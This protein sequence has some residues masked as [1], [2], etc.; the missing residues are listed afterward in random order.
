MGT[1]TTTTTTTTLDKAGNQYW[2]LWFTFWFQ[3]VLEPVN[4][5]P[6][7]AG[8]P[9]GWP[10]TWSLCRQGRRRKRAQTGWRKEMGDVGSTAG[11]ATGVTARLLGCSRRWLVLR[12]TPRCRVCSSIGLTLL[13]LSPRC[14]WS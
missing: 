12:L 8:S 2:W 6:Q 7:L 1:T 5:T 9:R 4:R 13:S 11:V 3:A 14:W 10:R